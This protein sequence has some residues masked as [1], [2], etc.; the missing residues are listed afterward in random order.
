MEANYGFRRWDHL[1]Q[2]ILISRLFKDENRKSPR[3]PSMENLSQIGPGVWSVGGVLS[4]LALH[5][6]YY[7]HFC[8]VYSKD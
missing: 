6:L 2:I 3:C 4:I 1:G 8:I 5:T 7:G